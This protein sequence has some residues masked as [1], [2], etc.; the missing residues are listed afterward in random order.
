MTLT[1]KKVLHHT[2]KILPQYNLNDINWNNDTARNELVALI[3]AKLCSLHK[4]YQLEPIGELH[5]IVM[6]CISTCIKEESCEFDRNKIDSAVIMKE[7]Y[8][9]SELSLNSQLQSQ[10]TQSNNSKR[11]RPNEPKIITFDDIQQRSIQTPESLELQKSNELSS[12][13][14]TVIKNSTVDDSKV[15]TTLAIA[16][17]SSTKKHKRR[18]DIKGSGQ[19]KFS[20]SKSTTA[21]GKGAD[22]AIDNSPTVPVLNF[23]FTI[24]YERK[25]FRVFLQ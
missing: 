24:P 13:A 21:D 11:Q 15:S 23:Y 6:E 16:A 4:E 7:G 3:S 10:Y 20:K 8:P 5:I 22:S 1:S 25:Y 14:S 12:L 19:I 9:R 18:D 2:K 17:T